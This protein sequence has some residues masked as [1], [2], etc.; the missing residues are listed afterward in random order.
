MKPALAQVCSLPTPFAQQV[1]DYAAG[2]CA[3][4]ELWLTKL[5]DYLQRDSVD[6]LGRLLRQHGM[7]VPVASFQGGLLLS[8]GDARD[9]A[10]D[11]FA[12]R[13]AL[14]QQ[15]GVQVM[16]LA[17]DHVGSVRDD[18]L[19]PLQ[20]SL[21]QAAAMAQRHSLRL[22]LEFQGRAPLL[23]NLQ[24][25]AV[26]VHEVASPALGIC[27][28]AFHFAVGPS[29]LEDLGYLSAANLFHVQ[30]CDLS[31]T[32]RELAADAQRIL[33][34]DG[35]LPLEPIIQHLQRI[36]YAG[37][38]SVELMNPQL[39]QVGSLAFGEIAMTALRRTLGQAEM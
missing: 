20:E 6:E 18:Q 10:W 12:R 2:Q 1:A 26:L 27:L 30:L 17:A 35:D 38:V 11:L 3:A 16:V 25:A 32:L 7:A 14:C 8:Q 28:D 33:P 36:G 29:K 4:L 23:N 37:Y 24:T 19:A 9:A 22:A 5:E 21:R 31:G 15:L 34:G 13:L 39:W